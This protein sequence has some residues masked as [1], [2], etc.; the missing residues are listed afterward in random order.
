MCS[1]SCSVSSCCTLV[2]NLKGERNKIVAS[3]FSISRVADLNNC[4]FSAASGFAEFCSIISAS[5]PSV[6]IYPAYILHPS[7]GLL[8]WRLNPTRHECGSPP[9]PASAPGLQA[10]VPVDVMPGHHDPTNYTLPQQPLHRCMFPLSSAYPTLQLTS[11]PYQADIDGVRRVPLV[12]PAPVYILQ[13]E[14]QSSPEPRWIVN[15][16]SPGIFNEMIWFGSTHA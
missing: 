16:E 13:S 3:L 12:T 10:S 11:N 2:I 5:S 4:S 15:S 6:S 8:G 7:T 1:T 14:N 9:S